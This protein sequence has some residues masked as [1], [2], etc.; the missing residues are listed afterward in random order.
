[1]SGAG[2]GP[3]AKADPW[4]LVAEG[5]SQTSR[6]FLEQFSRS[7]LGRLDL[8]PS[9][10]VVD[11]ACGPG[12]TALLL[13][14]EV[15]HISCIDFSAAMLAELR[16]NATDADAANLEIVEADG[17]ALPF[18]AASFNA[19]ISMF[20]LMFFPDRERGFAELHRVLK[21]GGQL[22]VSSWAPADRSPLIQVVTK[23]LQP[24]GAPPEPP[25]PPSGLEDPSI[26]EA[27]LRLAGFADIRVEA[28][29][30]GLPVDDVETFWHG[31]VRGTAPIAAWKHHTGAEEWAAIERQALDR[32]HKMLDHRL[33]TQLSSTAWLATARKP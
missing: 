4:N 24:E 21:L 8:G 28:V 7:G 16:R 18:Q 9:S 2:P 23:V 12:T 29:T 13:A 11:V 22:L 26:F 20:G 19:G 25:R 32:L 1:M 31:M 33:P 27:E 5:Y 17:Q 30:H 3:L 14:P 6:L 10:T 15:A